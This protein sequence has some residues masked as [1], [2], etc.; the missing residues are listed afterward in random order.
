[1]TKTGQINDPGF[2]IITNKKGSKAY[3][4]YVTYTDDG[5]RYDAVCV[6]A[7]QDEFEIDFEDGC[8]SLNTVKLTYL[9][10]RPEQLHAIADL[11]EEAEAHFEEWSESDMGRDFDA[12]EDAGETTRFRNKYKDVMDIRS[13]V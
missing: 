12:A 7:E 13:E 2:N 5:P 9:M 6:D 1:M 11:V 3:H 8:A 4:L 10:L